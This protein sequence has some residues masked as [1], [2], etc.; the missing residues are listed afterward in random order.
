MKNHL[1]IVFLSLLV[2]ES[3]IKQ[4]LSSYQ[5]VHRK[6]SDSIRNSPDSKELQKEGKKNLRK[7]E[8]FCFL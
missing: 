7:D 4:N 5:I 6:L 1:F 2:G 3:S 8:V